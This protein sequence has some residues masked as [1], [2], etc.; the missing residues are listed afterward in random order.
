MC[1]HGCV[2]YGIDSCRFTNEGLRAP[3][4]FMDGFQLIESI[5]SWGYKDCSV[6]LNCKRKKGHWAL[7]GQFVLNGC[8][9]ADPRIER[10]GSKILRSGCATVNPS[11]M[12]S[13]VL[14]AGSA[15]E[16]PRPFLAEILML[17][18]V[19]TVAAAGPSAATAI[20]AKPPAPAARC[21]LST[22]QSAAGPRAKVL[23]EVPCAGP[24]VRHIVTR[25]PCQI[26]LLITNMN[27]RETSGCILN[28]DTD[29][30][31]I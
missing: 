9:I 27:S 16:I 26:T 6:L 15:E 2:V 29:Q 24:C 4:Q 14:P 8:K 3:R 10:Q 11:L 20:P 17:F 18:Q 1:F 7:T 30:T 25:L 19:S 12:T 5:R 31:R 13:P 23:S 22:R 21:R 28:R